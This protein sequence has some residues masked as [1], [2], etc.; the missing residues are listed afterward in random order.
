MRPSTRL[1]AATLSRRV[2]MFM[3]KSLAALTTLTACLSGCGGGG[4]ELPPPH[5]DLSVL[6][7][8]A[9]TVTAA[10][11]RRRVRSGHALH[12][13]L[14]RGLVGVTHGLATAGTGL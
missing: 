10:A 5:P 6:Y 12:R 8:S 2:P 3:T 4:F 14:A 7:E 11:A 1:P 13:H 9:S